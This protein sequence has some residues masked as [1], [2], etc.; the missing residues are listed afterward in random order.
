MQ[1][2]RF[3]NTELKSDSDSSDSQLDSD[4][5]LIAKL[6]SGSGSE[7]VF[8]LLINFGHMFLLTLN[9]SFSLNDFYSYLF[10]E[11]EQVILL[12]TA[13]HIKHFLFMPT[14]LRKQFFSQGLFQTYFLLGLK[15]HKHFNQFN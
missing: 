13:G 9:K 15:I 5:T 3:R 2:S 6:E 4:A 11:F 12:L 1:M 7:K 8:L 14:F 10:V